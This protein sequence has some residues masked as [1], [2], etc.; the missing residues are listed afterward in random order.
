MHNYPIII[1]CSSQCNTGQMRC[2]H[3]QD[4]IGSCC[5]W[6]IDNQCNVFCD[7]PDVGTETFECRPRGN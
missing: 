7:P 3:Y 1:V 2:T 4:E 5:P 6:F